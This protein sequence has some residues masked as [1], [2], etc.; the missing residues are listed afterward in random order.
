MTC[1]TI[2][3]LFTV[4]RE[5][6]I[7]N[8]KSD[9]TNIIQ[10]EK[11]YREKL[12]LSSIATTTTTNSATLTST[13]SVTSISTT[14][15]VNSCNN[16]SKIDSEYKISLIKLPTEIIIEICKETSP[17]DLYSLSTICK[18]F[19]NL[20]WSKSDATQL[21]WRE[22][23][24]NFLKY[25]E[26]DPPFGLTEQKYIWLTLLADKCQF[27]DGSYEKFYYE[28]WPSMIIC[29]GNC[30]GEKTIQ[31]SIRNPPSSIPK[32]VFSLIPSTKC[33]NPSVFYQRFYWKSDIEN[34]MEILNG[35]DDEDRKMSWIAEK[36]IEVRNILHDMKPYQ[37]QEFQQ[38]F[39]HGIK[40]NK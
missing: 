2:C 6:I 12:D 13:T 36:E 33:F 3:E 8:N 30:F 14:V 17:Y 34:T 11:C 1:V 28:I 20:L 38:L 18:Y 35:F 4:L 29:C 16:N 27:C 21:I 24:K 5:F 9:C 19:R 26:L 10:P 22:S 40:N 7:C 32:E 31:L 25:P 37:K 39:S 15:T 23:R